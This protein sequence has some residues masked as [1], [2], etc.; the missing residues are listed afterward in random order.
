VTSDNTS[1][2]QVRRPGIAASRAVS[3]L[4]DRIFK[5]ER[6]LLKSVLAAVGIR[7]GPQWE[8]PHWWRG[9]ILRRYGVTLVL[10]VGA[11][12]GQY[13][14]G[15]RRHGYR[16]RIL[17]FEP[18]FE[19]YEALAL[20]AVDDQDWECT[21]LAL[22]DEDGTADIT[23]AGSSDFSSLL[24]FENASPSG[25]PGAVPVARESVRTARLDSLSPLEAA[26]VAMLK[27][28][29]QGFEPRVLAGGPE[30]LPRIALLECEL[31]FEHGYEDQPTFREMVDLIDELGFRPI[32]VAP[33]NIDYK[34]ASLTYVDMIFAR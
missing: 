26:D 22:S 34:T 7:V 16:G 23:V 11:N 33:G 13:A 12:V 19:A 32:W 1:T 17:S 3:A 4:A 15:L 6:R 14:V 5:R 31:V 30:M 18:V 21:R 27:L 24:A 28:D 2:D 29:V 10:D 25:V 9:E 8:D 20:K